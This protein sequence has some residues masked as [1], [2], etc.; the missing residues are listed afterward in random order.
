VRYCGRDFS[1][2]EISLIRSMIADDPK[3]TRFKLSKLV[4]NT[5]NW[6][7]I[8]GK[9][10]DMSCRVALLRMEADQLFKLPPPKNA[11]PVR[12]ANDLELE[13]AIKWPEKIQDFDLK[14]VEIEIVKGL[15]QSRLWNSYI[16]KYHYLGFALIPGA[17]LRYQVKV[18]GNTVA[19]LSFGASAWKVMPRD[20]YIGWTREQR[21][22]NLHLIINNS[23][24]LILPWITKKNLA[25]KILSLVSKRISDDW[26]KHYSYRPV[27]LETFVEDQRFLG[28]CYKAS[29]WT[30]LGKTQGR[31]K[32]DVHTKKE[33][34]IK[35]IWI[36]PI[37]KAFRKKLN[38]G[39]IGDFLVN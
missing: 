23:R 25:S 34:P 30:C 7:R 20:T 24:F 17:Q 10:K 6:L 15:K 36:L 14:D 37:D 4:C 27:L 12:K 35:T 28:T 11:K 2:S 39:K 5:M 8:D 29:N 18:N 22:Q 9:L 32:L 38:E 16:D 33:K 19:L 21:E 3:M 31:G 1:E 26:S 13:E